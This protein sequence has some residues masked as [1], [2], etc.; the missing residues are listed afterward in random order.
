MPLPDMTSRSGWRRTE[1]AVAACCAA[2]A[3]EGVAVFAFAVAFGEHGTAF[4]AAARAAMTASTAQRLSM[5]RSARTASWRLQAARHLLGLGEPSPAER[6][7]R[8]D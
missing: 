3:A 2:L 4:W 5:P 7:E 8:T 6:R 1:I